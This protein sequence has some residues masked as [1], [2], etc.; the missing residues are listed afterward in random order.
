MFPLFKRMGRP[1]Q[2][3][4]VIWS[5]TAV[6]SFRMY[7]T[8]SAKWQESIHIGRPLSEVFAILRQNN[9]LICVLERIANIS[10]TICLQVLNSGEWFLADPLWKICQRLSHWLIVCN[11]KFIAQ[12]AIVSIEKAEVVYLIGIETNIPF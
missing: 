7:S 3:F 9:R 1:C 2:Q 4:P 5:I 6:H 10:P 11:N 8:F 12:E